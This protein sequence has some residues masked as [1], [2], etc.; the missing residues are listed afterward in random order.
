MS[1]LTIQ[2]LNKRIVITSA[3]Q[4]DSV[5][6]LLLAFV[7][8]SSCDTKVRDQGLIETFDLTQVKIPLPTIGMAKWISFT[9]FTSHDVLLIVEIIGDQYF[10][11]A[12]IPSPPPFFSF[13]ELASLLLQCK[14]CYSLTNPYECNNWSWMHMIEAFWL[15]LIISSIGAT[16][17][18]LRVSRFLFPLFLCVYNY[19]HSSIW[20][21]LF[22]HSITLE[23]R[24]CFFFNK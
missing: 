3:V 2:R 22:P 5:L 11:T 10:P 23:Y 16:S 8:V 20:T 13:L 9:N 21:S 17:I 18:F 12:K 15:S 24:A 1:L 14:P 4:L 6:T 19:H 7:V